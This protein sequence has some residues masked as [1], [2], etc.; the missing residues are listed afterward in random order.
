[1]TPLRRRNN[2]D[3][4]RDLL[5][6]LSTF[7]DLFDLDRFFGSDSPSFVRRVPSVNIREN[8]EEFIIEV[9]AP[10][11]KKEDF[12]VNVE[13]NILTI[14]AE[15]E[16]EDE[17]REQRYTRREY[18]YNS[19]TR[20]FTLPEY[21]IGEEINARYEQG[22]LRISLPKKEEARKQAPRQIRVA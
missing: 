18:V 17:Q 12:K 8:A 19:F 15:K 16:E 6:P 7:T 9:A 2:G 14:S 4:D 10:G 13:Q 11:L 22:V 5:A 1:M 3:R 21:V 20:S